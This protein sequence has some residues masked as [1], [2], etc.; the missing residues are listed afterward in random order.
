MLAEVARSLLERRS[1]GDE[2]DRI[3]AGA[4]N[5]LGASEARIEL[6]DPS[7]QNGDDAGA[8]PLIAGARRVGTIALRRSRWRYPR[9]GSP[10]LPALASLLAVAIDQERLALEV[11]E[12]EALRRS[13]GLKT[14]LLRAVS[15]DLRSPLGTILT[16][17]SALSRR[18]LTLTDTDRDEL[19]AGIL[20]EAQRL[21][22]L[23]S[24]LL[25]LRA[26]RQDGLRPS[27]RFG[28]WIASWYRR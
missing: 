6:G 13:D 18:D 10:L 17:A 21:D 23:V 3:A 22:R 8:T 7:A 24:N 16:S 28:R 4:A 20:S 9:A 2:L 27:Q 11:L 26:C 1:V 15:H 14:A 25:D 5:A 19:L 12:A